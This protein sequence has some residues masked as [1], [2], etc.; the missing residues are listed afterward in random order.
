MLTA[1]FP[2]FQQLAGHLSPA[3]GGKA[4][5][6][7]GQLSLSP[8]AKTGGSLSRGVMGDRGHCSRRSGSLPVE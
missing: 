2:V 7:E 6:R 8:G 3:L 5:V 4:S 1:L